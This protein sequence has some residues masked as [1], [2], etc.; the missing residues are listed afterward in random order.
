[1]AKKKKR[2]RRRQPSQPFGPEFFVELIRL[3]QGPVRYY[4]RGKRKGRK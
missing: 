1:M 3:V 2:K 4:K